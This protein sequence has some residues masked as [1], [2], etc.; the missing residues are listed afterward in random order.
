M[1]F[2]YECKNCGKSGITKESIKT[3]ISKGCKGIDEDKKLCGSKDFIITY[4]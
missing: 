1:K 2:H 4:C 3:F